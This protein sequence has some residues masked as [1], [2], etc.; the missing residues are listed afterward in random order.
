MTSGCH[1]SVAKRDGAVDFSA[2]REYRSSGGG[3]D[4]RKT[5]GHSEGPARRRST[6]VRGKSDEPVSY[7]LGELVKGFA[8]SA[9][10]AADLAMIEDQGQGVGQKPDHRQ[11]HQGLSLVDSGMLEVTVGGDGLK[12]FRIDSPTAAAELMDEQ[13][14]D[15]AEFEIGGVEVGALF[16]HRRLALDSMAVFF[17]DS[18]AMPMFEANRFDDSHQPVGD[19]PVDLRQ[20]PVSNLPARFGVNAAGR[21]L[22]KAF[23]LAQQIG[24]V[25]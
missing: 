12:D 1:K 23:G 13:R 22:R 15:R 6:G 21:C 5:A 17:A 16:R 14:R 7:V 10:M 11:H 19:G 3:R 24:L 9:G 25:L 2:R 20:V 8:F 18:D 4:T